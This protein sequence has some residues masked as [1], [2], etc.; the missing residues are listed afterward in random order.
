MAWSS[1]S[2]TA[3]YLH[4][5]KSPEEVAEIPP[6]CMQ[7]A[8]MARYAQTPRIVPDAIFVVFML[9]WIASR[10][11]YFPF[12]IIHSTL[13]ESTVSHDPS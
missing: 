3:G 10:C 8:K 5:K 1:T 12:Y 11:I 4:L 6:S 9:S 2:P 13:F 7:S